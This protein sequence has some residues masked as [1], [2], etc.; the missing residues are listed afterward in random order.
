MLQLSARNETGGGGGGVQYAKP[1]SAAATL[2]TGMHIHHHSEDVH[3]HTYVEE[4]KYIA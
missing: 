3:A 4:E 1:A 2:C